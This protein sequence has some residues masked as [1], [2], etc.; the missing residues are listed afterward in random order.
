VFKFKPPPSKSGGILRE[1]GQDMY[2]R[3]AEIKKFGVSSYD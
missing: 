2:V 3:R 1:F